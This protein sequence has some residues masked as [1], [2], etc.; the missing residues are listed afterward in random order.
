MD[1]MDISPTSQVE[2]KPR[3]YVMGITGSPYLCDKAKEILKVA[4]IIVGWQASISIVESLILDKMIFIQDPT[5]YREILK[6][7][8]RYAKLHN[9]N[10]V[11][12]VLDDPLVYSVPVQYFQETFEDFTLDFVPCS[13]RFQLAAAAAG[14]SLENTLMVVFSPDKN[15]GIDLDL[16]ETNRTRM[17]QAFNQGSN[18]IISSDIEQSTEDIA[19]FLLSQKV[20]RTTQVLLCEELATP[21]EKLSW[22]TLGA[23]ASYNSHWNTIMVIPQKASQ[24]EKVKSQ[25]R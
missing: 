3:A 2:P 12:L 18:V 20:D 19:E 11:L 22:T 15:G 23:S 8:T 17:I 9:Q 25:I 21:A 1:R 14:V 6:T 10:I 24:N 13:S 4:D 7:A 5:Q 16:L